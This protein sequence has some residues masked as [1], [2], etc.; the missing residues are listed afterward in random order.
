MNLAVIWTVAKK[1]LIDLFRDRKT[2]ALGLFMGPVLIPAM[3]LGVGALAAKRVRTQLES[4][5]ELPVVGAEHA[6]NLVA[7][8][9]SRNIDILPPPADP[10]R[11]VRD[12][13]HDLVLDRP[14]FVSSAR[15]PPSSWCTTARARTCRSGEPG[16]GTDR[17][18]PHRGRARI[19]R[20]SSEFAV[21]DGQKGRRHPGGAARMLLVFLPHPL[22]LSALVAGGAGDRRHCRRTRAAV[23]EPLLATARAR[24]DHGRSH[25][26]LFGMLSPLL[27]VVR[28]ASFQLAPGRCGIDGLR[29]WTQL[30]LV[31]PLICWASPR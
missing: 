5:L 1:E 8:L 17:V 20:G 9:E 2:M 7:F 29:R 4:T 14:E 30:L 31:P 27:I 18:Q 6:P 15:Q 10:D 22:V 11:A 19:H 3:F 23:A 21:R 13:E 16:A 28:W 12:Q 25:A 26:C 24:G